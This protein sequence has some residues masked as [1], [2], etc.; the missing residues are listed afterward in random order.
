MKWFDIVE[1][2]FLM[3]YGVK[4]FICLIAGNEYE[5]NSTRNEFFC[6][7]FELCRQAVDKSKMSLLS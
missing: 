5:F 1:N 4:L 7:S 2:I 6:S 3:I